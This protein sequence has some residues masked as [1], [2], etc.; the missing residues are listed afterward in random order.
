MLIMYIVVAAAQRGVSGRGDR[1][2]RFFG[3]SAFGEVGG[4]V[5]CLVAAD[6]VDLL[7]CGE[8]Y[9]IRLVSSFATTRT[10]LIVPSLSRY[11]RLSTSTHRRVPEAVACG[12]TKWRLGVPVR[13][14]SRSLA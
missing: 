11:G 2:V 9:T 14:T 4:A 1:V 13:I 6:S 7:P 5:V 8:T 3:P 12:T 10:P